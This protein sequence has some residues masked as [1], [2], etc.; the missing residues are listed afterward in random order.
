VGFILVSRYAPSVQRAPVIAFDWNNFHRQIEKKTYG[1]MKFPIQFISR[2]H[3]QVTIMIV[4]EKDEKA[5]GK[6]HTS[7]EGFNCWC[8]YLSACP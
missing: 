1:L 8:Y 2:P 7:P 5:F 6:Q 3:D 4:E